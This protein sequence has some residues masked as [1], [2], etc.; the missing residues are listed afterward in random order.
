MAKKPKDPHWTDGLPAY[1]V[2]VLKKNEHSPGEYYPVHLESRNDVRRA[3]IHRHRGL[4]CI[5]G[6]GEKSIQTLRLW[7][8][9]KRDDMPGD[10]AI[11]RAIVVL[12]KVGYTVIP[13]NTRALSA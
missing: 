8:G 13:P 2:N 10:I 3:L 6:L 4:I 12:E 11:H 1:L 7:C 5:N 9:F